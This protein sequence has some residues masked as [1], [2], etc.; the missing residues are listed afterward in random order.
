MGYNKSAVFIFNFLICIA[1]TY[2]F[3][4]KIHLPNVKLILT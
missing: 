2:I 1:M 4:S 3:R